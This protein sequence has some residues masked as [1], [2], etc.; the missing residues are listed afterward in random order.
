[1]IISHKKKFIFIHIYKTAGTSI[2]KAILPYSR[3]IDFISK[4]FYP[5][6]KFFSLLSKIRKK[7]DGGKWIT[8]ISKHALAIEGKMHIGNEKWNSYFK[9]AFTRNPFTWMVSTYKEIRK[10]KA[11]HLNQEV[12][13]MDFEEFIDFYINKNMPTQTDFLSIDG[14]IDVDFVGSYE[15]LKTDYQI[16]RERLMLRK[17]ILPILNKAPEGASII[18]NNYAKNKILKYFEQDFNN[19]NYKR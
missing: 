5:T 2:S 18:I 15:N 16:L 19:F 14:K 7:H 10:D 4:H 3:N 13:R 8:G 9:F 6:K 12:N 1:M 11:H 17:K